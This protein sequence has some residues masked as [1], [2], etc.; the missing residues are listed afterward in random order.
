MQSATI[1]NDYNTTLY[2]ECSIQDKKF[3]K[4]YEHVINRQFNV[5][6]LNVLMG[7]SH[8]W[9]RYSLL[10]RVLRISTCENKKV[11]FLFF[12]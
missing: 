4:A 11:P 3:L 9:D 10:T 8:S 1:T 6:M 2:I 5:L 7:L 12:I